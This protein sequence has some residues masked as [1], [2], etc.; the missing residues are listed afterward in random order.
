[1]SSHLFLTHFRRFA[2]LTIAGIM[3][4]SM[5][6]STT[7]AQVPQTWSWSADHPEASFQNGNASTERLFQV[8][9]QRDAFDMKQM[10]LNAVMQHLSDQCAII[11]FAAIDALEVSNVSN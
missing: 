3:L 1:M 9:K 8:L 2:L 10:P 11:E 6:V 5:I 4:A 7:S